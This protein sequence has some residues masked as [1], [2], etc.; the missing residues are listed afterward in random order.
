MSSIFKT[1][2]FSPCCLKSFSWTGTPSGTESTL[3]NLPTYIT[4][5]NPNVA[6]LYI[7]DALSWR[8]PNA[9]LLAD[10]FAKEA[11]ATVYMPDFFGGEELDRTAILE[12]RWGDVDL[13]GFMQRN[14]REIREPEVFAAAREL[15]GKYKKLGSVGYCFG[16]WAVMVSQSTMWN[17]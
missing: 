2:T 7:Y 9:R 10:H 17:R 15:R 11:N 3:S 13:P 6:I 14:A 16:G 12:G 8:F 1:N 4:G 5:S